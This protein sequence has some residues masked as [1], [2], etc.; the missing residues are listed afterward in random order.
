V[1]ASRNS[2]QPALGA[3]AC[4]SLV[5]RFGLVF[6]CAHAASR[7]GRLAILPELQVY[8]KST[9]NPRCARSAT[10]RSAQSLPR[11]PAAPK[12]TCHN[13]ALTSCAVGAG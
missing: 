9:N 13:L 10:L 2:Q 8:G 6:H 1:A 4:A 3:S 7:K 12:P 11:Q 5:N